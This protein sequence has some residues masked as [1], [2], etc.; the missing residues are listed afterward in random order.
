MLCRYKQKEI[1][2]GN[3]KEVF[4]YPEFAK[5]L[6]GKRKSKW[7]KSSEAQERLNAI[8]SE[9]NFIRI[10]NCNFT[11][12]D[13]LITLEYTNANRPDDIETVKN[14]VRNYIRRVRNY[15][16]RHGFREIRYAIKLENGEIRGN[17]HIHIYLTGGADR[18]EIERLWG[19]GTANTK[20]L[21]PEYYEGLDRIASY[22]IKKP[23]KSAKTGISLKGGRRWIGSRNLEKPI[24]PPPKTISRRM[25]RNTIDAMDSPEQVDKLFPGMRVMDYEEIYNEINGG[26]YCVIDLIRIGGIKKCKIRE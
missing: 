21:Q 12:N 10:I 18:N 8:N 9:R 11:E 24:E 20:R 7:K 26:F 25:A 5:S 22:T 19:K 16:R 6:K 1:I 2:S 17:I 14:D 15:Y 3:R 13:Y 4:I 23:K